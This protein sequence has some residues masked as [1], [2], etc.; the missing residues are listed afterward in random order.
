MKRQ[1]E[2]AGGVHAAKKSTGASQAKKSKEKWETGTGT[3]EN[4]RDLHLRPS[5]DRAFPTKKR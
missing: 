2:E 4:K 1:V 5:Q 3:E